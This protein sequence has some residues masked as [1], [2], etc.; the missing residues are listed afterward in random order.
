[1]IHHWPT[2][3][4][5]LEQEKST[6]TSANSIHL[7]AHS[8]ASNREKKKQTK[9][10]K[11]RSEKKS[12]LLFGGRPTERSCFFLSLFDCIENSEQMWNIMTSLTV[13]ELSRSH[14]KQR[15]KTENT[16]HRSQANST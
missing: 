15:W 14:K 1:M 4:S 9:K 10:K 11:K 6:T 2:V 13:R 8:E 7:Q 16:A 5:E 3:S 12:L